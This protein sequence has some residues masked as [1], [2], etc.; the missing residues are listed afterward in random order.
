MALTWHTGHVTH[1]DGWQDQWA[2]MQRLTERVRASRDGPRPDFLGTEGY[3]DEVFSLFQAIWHFKDW[4][5]NDPAVPITKQDVDAWVFTAPTS[6]N[7]QAAHDLA[8]GSKHLELT[9]PAVEASQGR[10]DATLHVGSGMQHVFYITIKKTGQEF[11]AVALAELCLADW[12][13]FLAKY[14]LTP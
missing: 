10:N 3:R 6:L 4:L 9:K 11:E 5:D 7:L 8:N 12:R 1:G 2:R 13:A 14:N